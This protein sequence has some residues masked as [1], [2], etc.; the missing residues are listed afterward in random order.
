MRVD[1]IGAVTI[2]FFGAA[3]SCALAQNDEQ[4]TEGVLQAIQGFSGVPTTLA[5]L[6]QDSEGLTVDPHT[7][8]L[9]AAGSPDPSGQCAVWSIASNGAVSQVGVVPRPTDAACAPRGLEFR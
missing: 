8:I 7:G 1:R 3:L 6:P 2:C 9:Y 4:Q 5:T